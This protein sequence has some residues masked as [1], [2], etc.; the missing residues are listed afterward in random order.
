MG[1]RELF[2]ASLACE[3]S[4]RFLLQHS[5]LAVP[6]YHGPPQLHHASPCTLL[7]PP[8]KPKI[9]RAVTVVFSKV[10]ALRLERVVGSSRAAKMLKS[11]KTGTFLFC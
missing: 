8:F 6:I 10:D 1:G 5:A 7:P 4:C 9:C 11:K 3:H 2:W